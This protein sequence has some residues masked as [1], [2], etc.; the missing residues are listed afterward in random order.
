MIQIGR[1]FYIGTLIKMPEFQYL[2][3]FRT[4]YLTVFLLTHQQHGYSH[5]LVNR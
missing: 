4:N 2:C 3:L 5:L 1:F